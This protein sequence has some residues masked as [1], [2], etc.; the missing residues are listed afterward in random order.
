MADRISKQLRDAAATALGSPAITSGGLT[1]T[2]YKSRYHP[3]DEKKLA[4]QAPAF[5][6]TDEERADQENK[7]RPF[8]NRTF[9][10]LHI[11][12]VVAK[13]ADVED[14]LDEFVKLIQ[15]RIASTTFAMVKWVAYRGRSIT[16]DE[17][18]QDIL[19]AEIRFE[20]FY[21][22]AEN[23]VDVPL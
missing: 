7:H 6:S 5:V 4:T 16:P 20:A 17:E 1:V 2:P 11:D 14:V 18:N 21:M 13:S 12:V 8:I 23:A 9:L 19:H 10:A 22:A 15:H 3:V